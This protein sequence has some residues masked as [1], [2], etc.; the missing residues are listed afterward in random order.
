APYTANSPLSR[1]PFFL[2]RPS[3]LLHN[4]STH[5]LTHRSTL[6]PT[7][8]PLPLTHRSNPVHQPLTALH[9]PLT[10]PLTA[11]LTTLHQPLTTLLPHPGRLHSSLH[12]LLPRNPATHDETTSS[13]LYKRVSVG[14]TVAGGCS[15]SYDQVCGPGRA[16]DLPGARFIDLALQKLQS[17]LTLEE[18]AGLFFRKPD[19]EET[20]AVQDLPP[21]EVTK[22]D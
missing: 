8:R 18:L 19:S 22:Q 20:Q 10:T 3:P 15:G 11:P 12:S 13:C 6:P 16:D 2:T 9:Q 14:Q 7:H 4:R 21:A 5:S 17:H 1:H